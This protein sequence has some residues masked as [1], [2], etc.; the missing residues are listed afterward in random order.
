MKKVIF[1]DT[2]IIKDILCRKGNEIIL[3]GEV[4]EDKDLLVKNLIFV[5]EG[6]ENYVIFEPLLQIKFLKYCIQ[7]KVCP[8]I[9]HTHLYSSDDD[10]SK[11]D[12]SFFVKLYRCYKKLGGNNEIYAGLINIENR[13]IKYLYINENGISKLDYVTNLK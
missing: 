3:I 10:F 8:I 9:F 13:D 11:P 6:N 5:N 7:K 2:Q 12:I 1:L 4:L